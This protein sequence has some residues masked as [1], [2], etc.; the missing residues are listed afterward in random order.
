MNLLYSLEHVKYQG[1]FYHPDKFSTFPCCFPGPLLWL[2]WSE[3]MQEQRPSS[4]SSPVFQSLLECIGHIKLGLVTPFSNPPKALKMIGMKS[5]LLSITAKVII[6][7]TSPPCFPTHNSNAG[8]VNYRPDPIVGVAHIIASLRCQ[9]EGSFSSFKFQFKSSLFS[10][11][12][13]LF[14]LILHLDLFT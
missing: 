10:Y 11:L 4:P 8:N 9:C 2:I 13:L 3:T 12:F 14:A 1:L 5:K 7:P 6:S